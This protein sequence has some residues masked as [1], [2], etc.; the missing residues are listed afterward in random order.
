MARITA[1]PGDDLSSDLLMSEWLQRYTQ[2]QSGTGTGTM[3]SSR[4]YSI[5]E[6]SNRSFSSSSRPSD[7]DDAADSSR[8]F[9]PNLNT[10]QEAPSSTFKA[11]L[12][13]PPLSAP[14][15]TQPQPQ[16]QNGPRASTPV[17]A[18]L[19]NNSVVRAQI[20]P[21][22]QPPSE[23]RSSDAPSDGSAAS[24]TGPAL[25][26]N[27]SASDVDS[28]A[29]IRAGAPGAAAVPPVP[30]HTHTVSSDSTSTVSSVPSYPPPQP[31]VE[32]EKLEPVSELVSQTPV[33]DAQPSS[34]MELSYLLQRTSIS[35]H[36]GVPNGAPLSTA[37]TEAPPH[38]F[39]SSPALLPTDSARDPV[40][41][42]IKSSQ[43]PTT[44][45]ASS[46]RDTF[47]MRSSGV[48]GNG[49]ASN[50]VGDPR[51][52]LKNLDAA[53]PVGLTSLTSIRSSDLRESLPPA[54]GPPQVD[55]PVIETL[56]SSSSPHSRNSRESTPS[57]GT[58]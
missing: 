41:R 3:T 27:T 8:S 43:S 20:H 17:A 51:R 36:V 13:P 10:L 39:K 11:P 57:P 48:S 52:A 40:A 33:T 9:L 26:S 46:L 29:T 38:G 28:V 55:G 19:S 53:F 44:Q 34:D 24:S 56:S 21:Q 32:N 2:F 18:A 49:T 14:V 54:T 15:Q 50:E 42:H 4:L 35:N 25:Q 31:P 58:L 22:P 12:P 37:D 16:D 30:S 47:E 6:Q 7:P 45:K 23:A 1:T 5:P